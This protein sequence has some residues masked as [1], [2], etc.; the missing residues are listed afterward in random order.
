M[1]STDGSSA[2]TPARAAALAFLA[3]GATLFVQVLVH[4]MISAKLLSLTRL[5]VSMNPS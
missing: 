2:R 4:R 3:A 5:L 1:P